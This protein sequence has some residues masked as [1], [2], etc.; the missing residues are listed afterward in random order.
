[1]TSKPHVK[2]YTKPGC[3]LCEEAKQ[4]MLAAGIPDEY[5]F[6]EVNIEEDAEAH[7]RYSLE[8][9]VITING[10]KAFKYRLTAED[11]KRKIRRTR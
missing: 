6:E 10:H 7:E 3:H 5:I 11:F 1:M 8:I 4:E 2:L 9:P